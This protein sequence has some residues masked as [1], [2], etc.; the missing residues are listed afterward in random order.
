VDRVNVKVISLEQAP[1][2][3]KTFDAVA[4]SKFIIDPHGQLNVKRASA[5]ATGN[6]AAHS[7]RPGQPMI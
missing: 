6:A 7:S 5:E 3:Y 4:A 2:G 1:E